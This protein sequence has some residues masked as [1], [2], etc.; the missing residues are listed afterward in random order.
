MV[1]LTGA[2]V[3]DGVLGFV[4]VDIM[5]TL[6]IRVDAKVRKRLEELARRS[7]RSQSFL[8]SEA[9]A[10]YVETEAWQLEETEAGIADV[11]SGRSVSHERVAR[12]LRSWGAPDEDIAPL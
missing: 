10:A 3:A 9:I 5:E 2:P 12:W 7:K 1:L 8:A 11:E 6:S 4:P